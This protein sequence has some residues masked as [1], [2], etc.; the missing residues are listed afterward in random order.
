MEA[1]LKSVSNVPLPSSN[2]ANVKRYT[3]VLQTPPN[4]KLRPGC[5]EDLEAL[6]AASNESEGN[7]NE[8]TTPE[9]Y[10]PDGRTKPGALEAKRMREEAQKNFSPNTS[11]DI[12]FERTHKHLSYYKGIYNISPSLRFIFRLI[13]LQR[14]TKG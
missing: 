2:K 10:G 9:E 8:P 4:K 11:D 1:A 7:I 6:Q 12:D 5:K 3:N 14:V 13:F